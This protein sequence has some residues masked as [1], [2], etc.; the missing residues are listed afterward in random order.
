MTLNVAYIPSNDI[1]LDNVLFDE[2]SD[3]NPTGQ[4]DRWAAARAF[5]QERG[6]AF[7][8]YDVFRKRGEKPHVWLLQEPTR[9]QFKFLLKNRINPRR[10]I[11]AVTEP[12]V[13]NPWG[14]KY[15]RYYAPFFGAVLTWNP[16]ACS[17]RRRFVEH[18]FP[19]RIDANGY[20]ATPK[21]GLIVMIRSH[22]TG[23]VEGNLY[24]LRR[25][26]IRYYE[27]R[28]D[29]LFS[30]YGHGWND[31][32][33]PEPFNTSV[34]RG[35]TPDKRRTLAE[36]RFSMCVDNNR[37]PG[38]I[39]YDPVMSLACGTVPIYVPTR[40]ADRYLPRDV[41]IDFDGFA[42]LDE[43]TDHVLALAQ[44]SEYEAYRRRGHAFL[45]SDQGRV[46]RVEK[47][48][49]EILDCI[50]LCAPRALRRLEQRPVPADASS[51]TT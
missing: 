19:V 50:R 34:Y 11:V 2:T 25:D 6:I 10:T 22:K 12:V 46:L 32:A 28:G 38:Y 24:A 23:E 8:T 49:E 41:F 7:N 43:L 9:T 20:P 5:L 45:H 51:P 16:E 18:K 14:W 39:S 3:L 15:L 26:I 35:I 31:P 29:G 21:K 33:H 42:N 48:C 17:G 30:L 47:F 44:G 36:H 13:I 4:L 37:E 27:R 1:F 40:G